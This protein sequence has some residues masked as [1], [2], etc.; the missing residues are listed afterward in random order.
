MAWQY[1]KHVCG[2]NGERYQAYGHH[3]G[4]ERQLRA[5]E[6]RPCPDCRKK[7]AQ[8]SGLPI[9]HGSSR[10]I[11]WASDIRERAL[12]LAPA[13]LA[14]RIRSETSARWWIDNRYSLEKFRLI[15]PEPMS[16]AEQEG[17]SN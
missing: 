5:V 9:L 17:G 11:A 16:Q 15:S 12:R 3:S 8:E 1:P 10:Q 13:E 4:R 6:A 7:L 2:H 14:D